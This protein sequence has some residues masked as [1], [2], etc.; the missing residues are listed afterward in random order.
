MTSKI[1]LVTGA[2]GYIASRLIPQLL[3]RGYKVRALA[4]NPRR[5]STRNWSTRADI[6]QG[7][8]SD[9]ASL[10]SAM[11]DVHTAYY[12]VHNM[13]S[14]HGYT[15][16]EIQSAQKFTQAA[17]AA[18]VK[19][20]IYL[21]GLADPEQYIATHMRARIETGVALREGSVPVTEFRAG[22]IAGSGS[23]SFEMI[24][25]ITELF[26]VIPA[27]TWLK[28]KAQPIA[29]QN[30][31]DYLLAALENREGQGQV[32]EIGGS[33]ITTYQGLMESYARAR[34]L[35]RKFLL[36]PYIPIH[37][38]AYG[39]GVTTP[40][41]SP[42][43]YA[44]IGSLSHDSVILNKNAHDV[45]PIR[46]IDFDSA[47]KDALDRLHPHNIEH[48]WDGDQHKLNPFKREGFFIDQRTVR[49]NMS[50][51][52]ALNILHDF[53]MNHFVVESKSDSGVL[54]RS[55][56]TKFGKHWI[57]Y[58]AGHTDSVTHI[59]QTSYFA[60]YGFGGFLY[61]YLLYPFYAAMFRRLLKS[62]LSSQG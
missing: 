60:P 49:V 22:V 50:V 12:L 8:L 61:G 13:A 29:T 34:G 23:I 19:H 41:P 27:P 52:K 26:P 53:S 54:F 4:R 7:D 44:L 6:F 45:Y 59:T 11:K 30:V 33:K 46:L 20:I 1:I 47:I 40:V 15:K 42:I 37:F 51:E 28:N 3:D 14:G 10:A 43:A 55:T 57:E 32:F 35:K 39:V 16:I 2:T 25:F 48:I 9:S 58:N 24:R 5:L 18:G 17:A 21:G 36:L 31:I 38:M 62:I 56:Q